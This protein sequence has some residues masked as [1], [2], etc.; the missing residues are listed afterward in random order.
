[1]NDAAQFENFVEEEEALGSKSEGMELPDREN[2]QTG[3]YAPKDKEENKLVINLESQ[4]D[5]RE[6]TN[7]CKI[8]RKEDEEKPRWRRE[9]L[10]DGRI[11]FHLW[12]HYPRVS[13]P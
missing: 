13:Q 5:A 1:M 6:V 8:A 3:D 7:K 10:P 2:A 12:H 9:L 11:V 4:E